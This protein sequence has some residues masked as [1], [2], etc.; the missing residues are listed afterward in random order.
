MFTFGELELDGLL[1]PTG[2]NTERSAN[3][4]EHSQIMNTNHLQ[5]MGMNLEVI[6]IDIKL[7]ESYCVPDD[8]WNKL[9]LVLEKG[10]AHPLMTD[11][12][13]LLGRFVI[14][15]IGLTTLERSPSGTILYADVSL[16][17]KE[18]RNFEDKPMSRSQAFAIAG[19]DVTEL[20]I[21]YNTPITDASIVLNDLQAV[22]GAAETTNILVEEVAA[23]PQTAAVKY[24][25]V[26][27]QINL[28]QNKLSEINAKVNDTR[29]NIY[30]VATGIRNNLS[31]LDNA[32]LTL[33][34]AINTGTVSII[35]EANFN[36]QY[37]AGIF[38]R[39][40]SPLAIFS[41]LRR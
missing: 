8:I 11:N 32:V 12:G 29:S 3:Y 16:S 36:L 26:T 33:K 17:F 27:E 15:N 9:N 6:N 18:A 21:F 30:T 13:V 39:F 19:E 22:N 34:N 23:N 37:T 31:V 41:Q 38:S 14:T 24:A 1:A 10:E 40:S 28:M 7:H 25:K 20:R 2:Y 35:N 5:F 4:V